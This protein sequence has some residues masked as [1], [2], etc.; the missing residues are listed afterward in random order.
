M[1]YRFRFTLLSLLVAS[2]SI[3]RAA[4]LSP[5]ES[6]KH[7]TPAEGLEV[8]LAA[9]EP[10]VRQPVNVNFDARGRMWV[11]QYL[12]YPKPA[13]LKPVAVDSWLRTTYDQCPM[14]P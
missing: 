9:A 2:T 11:V 13:G 7:F 8:T 10:A 6:L 5:D 1:K 14:P 3:A 12:Q 4:G